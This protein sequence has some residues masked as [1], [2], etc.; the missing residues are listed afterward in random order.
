MID[1]FYFKKCI[2]GRKTG[3]LSTVYDVLQVPKSKS[4]N[5]HTRSGF[6]PVHGYYGTITAGLE[7]REE[8]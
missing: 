2:D 5:V 4:D 8:G 7:I 1:V 6:R 3:A